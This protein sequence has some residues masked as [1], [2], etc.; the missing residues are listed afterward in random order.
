MAIWQRRLLRMLLFVRIALPNSLN[1]PTAD[2]F[3][4]S[5]T[6]QIAAR[7]IPLLK[8]FPTTGHRLPCGILPCALTASQSITIRPAADFTRNR[9]AALPA[10]RWSRC[11]PLIKKQLPRRKKLLRQPKTC[12]SAG[13]SWPSRGSAVF[14]WRRM[15]PMMRQ[16]AGCDYAREG[17]KSPWLLW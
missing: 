2:T 4:L 3:T 11:T 10:A 1:R 5:Q 14:I 17:K 15:P 8:I 16:C 7:A 12:C 9:I 13:P 6:V